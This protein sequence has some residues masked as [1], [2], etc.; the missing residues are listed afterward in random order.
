MSSGALRYMCSSN[1][2]DTCTCSLNTCSRGDGRGAKYNNLYYYTL[3]ALVNIKFAAA[4]IG[5][6]LFILFSFTTNDADIPSINKFML[7]S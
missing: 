3:Y 2:H 1:L 7:S 6:S 4:N 5:I